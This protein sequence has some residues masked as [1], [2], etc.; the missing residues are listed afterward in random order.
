MG[1]VDKLRNEEEYEPI[2]IAPSA[3]AARHINGQ[4][5]HS[6]FGLFRPQDTASRSAYIL[7]AKI[8]TMDVVRHKRPFFI[9]DEVSMLSRDMF[10]GL[11]DVCNKVFQTPTDGYRPFGGA[12]VVMFGDFGQLGPIVKE[13]DP[14]AQWLFESPLLGDFIRIRLRTIHRQA[15]DQDFIKALSIVRN[16]SQL[17]QDIQDLD[18]VLRARRIDDLP[19]VLGRIMDEGATFIACTRAKV[20]NMNSNCLTRIPSTLFLSN[21]VDTRVGGRASSWRQDQVERETGLDTELR[22][23]V[24]ARVMITAN[25]DIQNGLVNGAMATVLRF[26]DFIIVL[27]MNETGAV[28]RLRRH[29]QETLDGKQSRKQFPITLAYALTVH[30]VQS[31]TLNKVIVDFSDTFASGQAYVALSRVRRLADLEIFGFPAHWTDIFP[32]PIVQQYL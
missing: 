28:I 27:R 20:S 32:H 4:T 6:Y 5:I 22:L 10:E 30:R 17:P 29:T 3:V 23:K 24:G 26:E 16:G 13:G 2:V 12:P 19:R 1:L 15:Q 11:S 7:D 21:A 9:I 25:L 31:L 18:R 8:H 14:Q